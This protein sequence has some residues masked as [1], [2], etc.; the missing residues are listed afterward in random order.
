VF[1]ADEERSNEGLRKISGKPIDMEDFRRYSGAIGEEIKKYIPINYQ[2][3]AVMN[4]DA[5]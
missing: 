2:I 5:K 1:W 3:T 4:E